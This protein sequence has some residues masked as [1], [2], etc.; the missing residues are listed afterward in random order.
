VTSSTIHLQWRDAAAIGR[1]R[2]GVSLHSHTLHS[3]ESLDFIYHAAT[4]APVLSA[5]VRHGETVYRKRH[6]AALDLTRGWWTPPLGPHDAWLLE[7][8]QIEGL[9]QNAIVSITDHDNI[10][11]PVALQ[12]LD[13]CRGTPISVEWTVPFGPTFFHLGVHNLPAAEARG[14]W[15]EMDC[16]RQNPN[17]GRLRDLLMALA[18]MDHVLMVFNHPLWDERGIGKAAHREMALEFLRR[19]GPNVHALELNGLRPWSEN[20][21][22]IALGRAV[23]KPVISGGDRHAIEPNALL[24][25]TNAETFEEFAE[26]VRGGWSNVLVMRHYRE[27]YGLRILHNIIDVLRTYER[28]ANGWLLWSDRVFYLCQDGQTRSL[29][30]LF[31]DRPPAAVA[32]FVGAMKFAAAPRVRRF[33]REAFA[34]PEEVTL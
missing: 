30:Q 2:T 11:A 6:G 18:S 17:E 20:R 25:V 22:V 12:V 16:Y 5:V 26:E 28:H 9:D 32:V 21:E 27:Q 23:Q 19:F 8:A 29:T 7:K 14:L 34:S 1:F 31:G 3:R 10:E 4:R 13:E 15:A 24:N 33:L